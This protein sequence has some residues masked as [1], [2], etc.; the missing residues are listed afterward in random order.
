MSGPTRLDKR[1]QACYLAAAFFVV[2]YH[3]RKLASASS[4]RTG[5]GF[6]VFFERWMTFCGRWMQIESDYEGKLPRGARHR[7]RV[8]RG[9]GRCVG[10]L[11]ERAGL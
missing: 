9:E 10:S 1:P 3:A 8:F 2:G 5:R 4:C 6:Y 7:S 11:M